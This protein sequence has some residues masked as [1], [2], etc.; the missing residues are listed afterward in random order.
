LVLV[1]SAILALLFLSDAPSADTRPISRVQFGAVALACAIAARR[2]R[3]QRDRQVWWSLAIA[4]SMLILSSVT[5]RL[6]WAPE[7]LRAWS[8]NLL[9]LAFYPPAVYACLRIPGA[10]PPPERRRAYFLDLMLVALGAIAVG[11][12]IS[13]RLREGSFPAGLGATLAG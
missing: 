4:A 13:L 5:Y 12:Y 11:G 6:P 2:S 8:G 10:L 7:D 3:H 9:A 1:P